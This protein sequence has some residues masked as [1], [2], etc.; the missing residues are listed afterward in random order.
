MQ[1]SVSFPSTLNQRRFF[2]LIT[3]TILLLILLMQI[4]NRR[5]WMHDFEVYYRASQA[6]ANGSK[7][8]GLAFG[9]DSGYYKYSPF[10]LYLFL[11]LSLLPFAI[12]KIIFFLLISAAVITTLILSAH[13][14]QY[15]LESAKT[16]SNGMLFIVLGIV[17]S[18]VFRELH[19]GNVNMILLLI[20]LIILYYILSGKQLAAGILFALVLFVKPHF[21]IL[22]PLLLLRKQYKLIA[23]SLLSLTLGSLLP[24]LVTGISENIFL[25]KEWFQTM[26]DH[27]K[28]LLQAYDTIYSLFLH[29][30]SYLNILNIQF[31]EKTVVIT[32]LFIVAVGFGWFVFGNIMQERK[33]QPQPIR[34][35]FTI[36]FLILI[37]L[38]PSLTITDA[39]H[40][41]L[42]IP[43]ILFLLGMMHI[44]TPFWFKI[45]VV[46]AFILYAMNIHDLI[47]TSLSLWLTHNGILGLGNLMLIGLTMYGYRNFELKRRTFG[48]QFQPF[49]KEPS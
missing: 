33:M 18:Q 9:L 34:Q 8:Y 16:Y 27:N 3:C 7:I 42:S 6:F 39:E 14:L 28:S 11:P 30:L 47:G 25:H 48:S 37:A 40:F 43:L 12:A 29:F 38:I 2:I 20:T 35:S 36:E 44:K 41:L 49:T 46:V 10:A 23:I 24:A 26:Q 15:T 31:Y 32:L 17:S 45:A 1:F 13:L 21:I 22:A 19:L 4:V 5:F